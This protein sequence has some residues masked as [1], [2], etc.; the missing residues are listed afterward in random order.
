VRCV[1]RIAELCTM[2]AYPDGSI[3]TL[4]DWDDP[5]LSL[6]KDFR[7][8]MIIILL[9]GSLSNRAAIL[10]VVPIVSS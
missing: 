4:W 8:C 3:R 9:N 7:Y 2:K 1:S 5:P 6:A 10:N